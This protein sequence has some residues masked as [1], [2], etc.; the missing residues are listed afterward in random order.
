MAPFFLSFGI[1]AVVVW[2]GMWESRQRF[3]RAVEREGKPVFG[4]PRFPLPVISTVISMVAL[5]AWLKQTAPREGS[6]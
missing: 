3:P 5:R 4:F 2:V 1:C 6:W